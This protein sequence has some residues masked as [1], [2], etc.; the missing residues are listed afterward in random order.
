MM[1]WDL[2][3]YLPDDL[4][5]KV[6]RATMFYGIECREPFL[7]HRLV[8]FAARVPLDL[9]FRNG[10]QK[11]ILKK[12]LRRYLPAE[13]FERKKR[14]F[15]IPIFEWFSKDLDTMFNEYL[16][17]ENL[18]KTPFLNAA[19]IQKELRKY[20]QYKKRNQSYNIEKMWRLLSFMMWHK[21]WM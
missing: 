14:G 15:S 19:T 16:S 1:D 9:K 13:F 17:E 3:Y 2:K 8:E 4:L 21:R 18:K 11:Y 12:L 5:V 6:D 7:D 20:F 10:D